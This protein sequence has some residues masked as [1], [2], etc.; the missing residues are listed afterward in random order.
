MLNEPISAPV[1]LSTKASRQSSSQ[2]HPPHPPFLLSSQLL[3][4]CLTQAMR[5]LMHN[6]VIPTSSA[7]TPIHLLCSPSSS[8]MVAV[9][10]DQVI[11][12]PKTFD[13]AC[14]GVSGC[15]DLLFGVPEVIYGLFG[16]PTFLKLVS[17]S[18]VHQINS[19]A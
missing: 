14:I 2:L 6:W 7:A 1:F 16:A 13:S 17:L 9:P 12:S 19:L 4:D 15:L 10:P 5:Q 18:V 3:I 8:G 11:W